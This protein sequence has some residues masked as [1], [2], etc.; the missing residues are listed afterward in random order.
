MTLPKG[1]PFVTSCEVTH[2]KKSSACVHQGRWSTYY[3]KCHEERITQSKATVQQIAD[4]MFLRRE[5]GLLVLAIKGYQ[6]AV[7][8]FFSLGG[9]IFVKNQVIAI[10][11]QSFEKSC[12]PCELQHEIGLWS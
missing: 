6:G 8:H 1:G 10:L 11:F 3:C 9:I 7:H 4:F 12:L 5:K 2:A